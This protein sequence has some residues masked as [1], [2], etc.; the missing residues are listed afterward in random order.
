MP[1]VVVV[2]FSLDL[3]VKGKEEKVHG[4]LELLLSQKRLLI[5]SE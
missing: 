2:P 4:A 1:F 3:L 5:V